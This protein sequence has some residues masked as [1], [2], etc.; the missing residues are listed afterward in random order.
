PPQPAL[1][2][3]S[4]IPHHFAFLLTPS[5]TPID[6]YGPLDVLT[7]LSMWYAN[8]TKP[9]H[10]SFI[11]PNH[12]SATTNPPLPGLNFG[13]DIVPTITF[14]EYAALQAKNFTLEGGE[15]AREKANAAKG[16]IDVLLIPG[17]GGTRMNISR[18]IAFT[19]K[20]YPSLSHIIS[21]CTGATLLARADI[22]S[23]R[24]ATTNKKA[25]TWATS[26]GANVSWVKEARWVRDGNVYTGSGVSAA[27][28]TAFAFVGDV[29]GREVAGYVAD[30]SEYS[31]WPSAEDDPFAKRWGV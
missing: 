18:E 1:A 11:S 8:T 23:H 19:K 21:V 28:D 20:I 15:C 12:T 26:F 7:A 14:D 29:Y 27:V 10:L 24:R 9:M 6:L 3:T 4:A 17:G 2:N 5:I 13:V 22:L 16:K 30:A 31:M 25:W